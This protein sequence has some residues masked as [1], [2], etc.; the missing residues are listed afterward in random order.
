MDFTIPFL[1]TKPSLKRVRGIVEEVR[2][3]EDPAALTKLGVATLT[4]TAIFK[5]A[6][7]IAV[8]GE[9][10]FGKKIVIAAGSSPLIPPISGLDKT[11]LFL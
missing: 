1:N 10:V 2:S 3:H 6:H 7:I 4:G 8:D 9:E 5:S 11:P